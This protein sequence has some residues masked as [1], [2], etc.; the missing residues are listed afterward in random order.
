MAT[1]DADGDDGHDKDDDDDD[2]DDAH[3]DADHD[4]DH[5]H[6]PC[7]H[8]APV[9]RVTPEH[10]CHMLPPAKPHVKRVM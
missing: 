1:D 2:H 3:D 4:D 6:V 9:S 8:R 10:A 5:L 7:Y